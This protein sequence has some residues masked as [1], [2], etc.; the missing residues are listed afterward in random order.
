[1]AKKKRVI[2]RELSGRENCM[3]SALLVA[4]EFLAGR[5]ERCDPDLTKEIVIGRL[6]RALE[7]YKVEHREQRVKQVAERVLDWFDDPYFIGGGRM[8]TQKGMVREMDEALDEYKLSEGDIEFY[9]LPTLL[10]RKN[11]IG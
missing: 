3:M 8:M 1:M 2:P 4:R 10:E 11:G 6:V 9:K 5:K 7:W